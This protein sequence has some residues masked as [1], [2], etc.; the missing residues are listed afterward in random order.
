[1]YTGTTG[2]TVTDKNPWGTHY[3]YDDE[4]FLKTQEWMRSMIEKGYAPPLEQIAGQ[5]SAEIFAAGK[6]AMLV[7]GSWTISGFYS[8][9]GVEVGT[10]PTPVGPEGK[11]ASMFNGVADSIWSG[12]NKGRLPKWVDYLRY[13]RVPG[14]GRQAGRRVPC[15]RLGHR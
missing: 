2:W 5:G 15:H 12:S 14:R 6:Y 4:R 8:M 1:M 11:R 13:G 9:K 3:N 7:A 10:A